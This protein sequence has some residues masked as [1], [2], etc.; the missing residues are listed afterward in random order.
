[1]LARFNFIYLFILQ[2]NN[3]STRRGHKNSLDQ[4]VEITEQPPWR[5]QDTISESRQKQ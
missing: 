3:M 4:N 5:P 2:I 1:M